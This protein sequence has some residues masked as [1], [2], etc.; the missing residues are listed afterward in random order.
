MFILRGI[1]NPRPSSLLIYQKEPIYLA[2]ERWYYY[3][4]LFGGYIVW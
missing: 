3:T 2:I 4:R 1:L